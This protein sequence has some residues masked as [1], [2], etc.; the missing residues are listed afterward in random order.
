MTAADAT[1]F[2]LGVYLCVRVIAA[3][4]GVVD[5]WYRIR[6]AYPRVI[7]P[8]VGWCGTTAAIVG[9][10]GAGH[11]RALLWGMAA[12][13]LLVLALRYAVKL[14]FLLKRAALRS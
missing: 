14:H 8:L 5:L 10:A 1:L 7:L 3:L 13:V 6:S 11:R 12:Y 2:A 4:Y 9:L